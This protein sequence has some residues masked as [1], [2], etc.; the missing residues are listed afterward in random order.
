VDPARYQVV[1]HQAQSDALDTQVPAKSLVAD[2]QAQ[3]DV[4]GDQDSAKFPADL[5][6]HLEADKISVAWHQQAGNRSAEL[7]LPAIPPVSAPSTPSSFP[8][9][10]TAW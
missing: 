3:S 2:H 6:L 1:D 5:H 9:A 10:H 7:E 4:P 8:K